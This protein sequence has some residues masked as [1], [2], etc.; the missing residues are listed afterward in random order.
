MRMDECEAR[1]REIGNDS[2]PAHDQRQ[3]HLTA[4]DVASLISLVRRSDVTLSADSGVRRESAAS[5]DP[6]EI[7]S[8]SHQHRREASARP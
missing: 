5:G 8:P 3:H 4:L 7:P 6:N 1:A 2:T